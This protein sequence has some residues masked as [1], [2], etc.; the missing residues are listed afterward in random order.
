MHAGR[1]AAFYSVPA[2]AM[3]CAASNGGPQFDINF[4]PI[5]YSGSGTTRVVTAVRG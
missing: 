4:A 5:E 1:A 3:F 2:M